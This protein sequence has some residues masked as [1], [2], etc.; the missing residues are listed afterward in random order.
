MTDD[1]LGRAVSVLRSDPSPIG[2]V[3]DRRYEIVVLIGRGGMGEVYAARDLRLNREVALKVLAQEWAESEAIRRFRAEVEVTTRLDHPGI[4]PVFDVG[5]FPDG[6]VYYTMKLVEGKTLAQRMAEGAPLTRLIAYVTAACDAL[7]HAH[8]Q[9]VVHRDLKP[10]NLMVDGEERVY[11]LDWGIARVRED[12]PAGGS[13]SVRKGL[14]SA[15]AI[16]GTAEYMSPEQA[17]GEWHRVDA[18]SDVYSLGVIL[19]EIATGTL[20]KTQ[21]LG[22]GALRPILRKAL[23]SDPE[24]R[25]S[26]AAALAEDLRRHGTPGRGFRRTRWVALSLVVLGLLGWLGSKATIKQYRVRSYRAEA[27]QAERAGDWKRARENWEKICIL[28][29]NDEEAK[30]R[31]DRASRESPGRD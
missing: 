10:A 12:E 13:G 15:G 4:V 16:L 9:G 14:T 8:R 5:A 23:A 21:P 29:P 17:R 24:E 18:R 11:V 27:T 20:P 30:E 25:Y 2:L 7:Q 3:I 6:R 26:D 31:F 28:C 19:H 1:V 22:G